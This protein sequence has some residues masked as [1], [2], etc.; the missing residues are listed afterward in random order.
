MVL[1]GDLLSYH[2][3]VNSWKWDYR[4]SSRMGVVALERIVDNHW[5]F[6]VNR[7]HM[8]MKSC[9]MTNH[10]Y[11]NCICRKFFALLLH[12]FYSFTLWTPV[13]CGSVFVYILVSL[14]SC[15][16]WTIW[17][18]PC[19]LCEIKLYNVGFSQIMVSC[20]IGANSFIV[21]LIESYE[22]FVCQFAT[23]LV[24]PQCVTLLLWYSI[25]DFIMLWFH[26][27][28]LNMIITIGISALSGIIAPVAPFINIVLFKSDIV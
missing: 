13:S 27:A 5:A 20:P 24:L 28:I 1:T 9:I 18:L 25:T 17:A 22:H 11:A 14:Y 21:F 2:W 6:P 4:N 3:C 16:R 8:T 7:L 15:H 26:F 19:D 23:R 10:D 12:F